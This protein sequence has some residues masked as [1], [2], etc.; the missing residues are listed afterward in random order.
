MS[1][2]RKN[3][4]RVDKCLSTVKLFG[5]MIFT[6]LMLIC[7]EPNE[8]E[9][10]VE[11]LPPPHNEVQALREIAAELGKKDWNFSENPCSNKSSSFTEPLPPNMPLA[12]NSTVTC[13][14][15]PNG[16]CHIDAIYLIGQDL[17]GVLPRSLVKLPYIKTIQLTL[18]YLKG[19]I[20]RE[21]AALKLEILTL[22]NN[23]FSGTIPPQLGKLVNL[24]NLTL[25][26]NFL[27][28]KFPWGLTKL[29][30][31]KEL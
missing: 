5:N 12:I 28:G 10:Q 22:E 9:A 29:S 14:C 21:W 15:S 24:E 17:D 19:T 4:R 18:N 23:L 13:S 3:M 6:V 8:V 26:A 16:E 27:T 31:L 11:P 30:N 7:M 1:I 25:S 20:P 2:S